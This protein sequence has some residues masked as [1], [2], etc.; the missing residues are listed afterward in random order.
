MRGREPGQEEREER[1]E[2]DGKG[3][4]RESIKKGEESG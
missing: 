4:K 3:A 2:R 1:E